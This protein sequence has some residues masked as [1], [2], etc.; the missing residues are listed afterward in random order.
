[1][2]STYSST[3]AA[4]IVFLAPAYPFQKGRSKMTFETGGVM[5]RNDVSPVLEGPN[6][7]GHNF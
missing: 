5:F 1:M 7:T 2:G 3:D 6:S 4:P